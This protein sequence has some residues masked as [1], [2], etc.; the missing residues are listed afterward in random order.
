MVIKLTAVVLEGGSRKVAALWCSN[1]EFIVDG[2]DGCN[3]Y[4]N[5]NSFGNQTQ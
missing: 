3:N 2:Y 5:Q 1:G 4:S